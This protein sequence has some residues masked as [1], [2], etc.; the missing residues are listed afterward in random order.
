MGTVVVVYE[1][2]G[3]PCTYYSW[4]LPSA[5]RPQTHPQPNLKAQNTV[6]FRNL[7]MLGLTI[8]LIISLCNTQ[9]SKASKSS[10]ISMY[11]SDLTI[12]PDGKWMW[13]GTEWIPAP[14]SPSQS[15]NVNLHDSVV[16]GDV[17]ITQNNAEDIATA[18]VQA[19]ERMGFSGQSSPA[20][21]TPSQEAE[22]EKV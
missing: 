8:C 19:L 20:E 16:G 13:T 17:I 3:T 1:H 15:A 22:V 4:R 12:S 7:T 6:I 14:P 21:L 5:I 9:V 10:L 18:M 2:K 11:M